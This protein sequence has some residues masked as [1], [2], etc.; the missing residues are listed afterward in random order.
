[1]ID[2]CKILCYS[3]FAVVISSVASGVGWGLRWATRRPDS[4][5]LRTREFDFRQ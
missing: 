4:K 2:D 5:Y 1:M 3:V